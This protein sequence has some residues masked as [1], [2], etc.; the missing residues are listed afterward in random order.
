MS[1]R[2]IRCHHNI[3]EVRS[4]Q[5]SRRVVTGK[6][7]SNSARRALRRTDLE[8]EHSPVRGPFGREPAQR[9][10]EAGIDMGEITNL[11]HNGPGGASSTEKLDAANVGL[12]DT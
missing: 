3:L 1:P 12:R 9:R 5:S 8:G 4:C 2:L 11:G 6:R 7:Q 10:R